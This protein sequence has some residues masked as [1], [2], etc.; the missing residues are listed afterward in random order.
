[1]FSEST[2]APFVA[3]KACALTLARDIAGRIPSLHPA[4]VKGEFQ[5]F[6]SVLNDDLSCK[7]ALDALVARE[8]IHVG[9]C[10]AAFADGRPMPEELYL[11][12]IANHS[13]RAALGFLLVKSLVENERWPPIE[14]GNRFADIGR[15]YQAGGQP[16]VSEALANFVRVF[17]VPILDELARERSAH[18]ILRA[19]LLRYK[20]RCEWFERD[21]LLRLAQGAEEGARWKQV[22]ARLKT[23]LHRY[24]FDSGI[25][26]VA[27]PYTPSRSAKADVVS[28]VLPDGRR[29]VLEAKVF[30]P[31]DPT[32]VVHGIRQAKLY[33]DEWSEP[34]AYCLVYNRTPGITLELVGTREDGEFQ[35]IN[36]GSRL[37]NVLIVNISDLDA[38]TNTKVPAKATKVRLRVKN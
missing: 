16:N 38:S 37:V 10:L 12:G 27:E 9:R 34:V 6:L 7:E 18:N 3:S 30:D 4:L 13:Q 5:L 8:G 26:F 21:R 35:L 17:A 19:M 33:A 1:M 15:L 11:G 29:L 32:E 25:E 2:V 24:L 20:H 36:L 31:A 22:E 28:A 23:D 14:T